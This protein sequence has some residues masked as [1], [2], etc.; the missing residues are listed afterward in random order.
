MV[1]KRGGCEGLLGLERFDV[2]GLAEAF[3]KKEEVNVTGYEW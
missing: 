3:L 1:V 2:L